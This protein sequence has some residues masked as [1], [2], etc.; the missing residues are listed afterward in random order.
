M[1][2]QDRDAVFLGSN[3]F[4]DSGIGALI[5]IYSFPKA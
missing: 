5:P 3:D 4:G 2:F 1:P